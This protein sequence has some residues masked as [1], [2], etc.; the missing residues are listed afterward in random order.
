MLAKELKLQTNPWTA[1]LTIKNIEK[2]SLINH[3]NNNEKNVPSYQREEKE[4]PFQWCKSAPTFPEQD[5]RSPAV[6][7]NIFLAPVEINQK[8]A[9]RM[10]LLQQTQ[11]SS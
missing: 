5:S 11:C 4:I 3:I 8:P 7:D 6:P 9:K 1:C 10:G 2:A